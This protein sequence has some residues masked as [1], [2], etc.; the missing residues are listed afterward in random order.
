MPRSATRTWAGRPCHVLPTARLATAGLP[1]IGLATAGGTGVPPVGFRWH[2]RPAHGLRRFHTTF[3]EA[4]GRWPRLEVVRAVGAGRLF[5]ALFP[6]SVSKKPA[7]G[8][9]G[10]PSRTS[11]GWA[12]SLEAQAG[13]ESQPHLLAHGQ[14]NAAASRQGNVW[15]GNEMAAFELQDAP[16]F[17][18]PPGAETRRKTVRTRTN[19]LARRHADSQLST[20]SSW[21]D[22]TPSVHPQPRP[23]PCPRVHS[24]Y[25]L[26]GDSDS[27]LLFPCLRSPSPAPCRP[28]PPPRKS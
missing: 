6:N 27:A 17:A 3:V 2:G 26:A 10:S 4:Y 21:V 11:D 18:G 19:P 14:R 28:K 24:P 15:Q 8:G 1:A 20:V 13:S 23:K 5:T 25:L 16:P 12:N 7:E 22:L 9:G